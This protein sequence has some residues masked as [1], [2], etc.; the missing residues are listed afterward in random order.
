[1]IITIVPASI[2]III[3]IVIPII[4]NIM[5]NIIPYIPFRTTTL[6]AL[7]PPL[8]I[9][10]LTIFA[11]PVSLLEYPTRSK[12]W[13][14]LYLVIHILPTIRSRPIVL[15]I[16]RAMMMVLT[17]LGPRTRPRAIGTSG[18]VS[19]LSV[20]IEVGRFRGTT[21]IALGS[22]GK[23]DVLAVLVWAGPV[24][25]FEDVSFPLLE[26]ITLTEHGRH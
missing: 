23:V 15:I 5:Y 4:S 22:P 25:F 1:M 18:V 8:E 13:F 3:I 20:V 26:V 7:V 10:I 2:V 16:L 9:Y 12:K 6:I 24:S 11:S 14:P 17:M 21:S 19:F